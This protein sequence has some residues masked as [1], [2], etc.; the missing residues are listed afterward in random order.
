MD[1][2]KT[3]RKIGLILSLILIVSVLAVQ[4]FSLPAKP[5]ISYV[6]N[7]T[8]VGAGTGTARTGDDG[9]YITTINLNASQQNYAWKAYVGNVSGALALLDSANYA[10]YEWLV[11]TVDQEVY[12]SRND[13]VDWATV[14]CSNNSVILAEDTAL[15]LTSSNVKSINRTFNGSTHKAFTVSGISIAQNDCPAIATYVN[16]TAQTNGVN[17]M[18]QEVLL[19]DGNSN[20]V[21]A[22]LMNSAAQGYNNQNYDFQAIVAD[23]EGTGVKT[24]YY[25]YV[26]LA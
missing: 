24:T 25:F 4:V 14:N 26:E 23:D 18:F 21:Y 15:G 12:I 11:P 16:G 17:N 2:H 9:G 19:A 5:T 3:L 10:I 6:S 13:T 7:S 20:L 22:A 8:I 1:K